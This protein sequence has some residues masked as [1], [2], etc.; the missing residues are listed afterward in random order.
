MKCNA[1]VVVEWEHDVVVVDEESGESALVVDG[2][3]IVVWGYIAV[4]V[5]VERFPVREYTALAAEDRSPEELD[6]TMKA[7][8]VLGTEAPGYTG[9]QVRTV[10]GHIVVVALF[11]LFLQPPL[12]SLAQW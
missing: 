12:F 2:V 4:V 5:V 6:K 10:P 1:V 8:Q 11:F 3:Q 7:V 9:G